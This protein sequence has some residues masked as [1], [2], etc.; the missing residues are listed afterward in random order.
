MIEYLLKTKLYKPT[1]RPFLVPRP[2]LI[3]KLDSGLNGKLTLVSAPAGFGKTTLLADWLTAQSMT[4]IAWLSLDGRDNDPARFLAY[5]VAALQ[6]IA[7]TLGDAIA[8]TLNGFMPDGKE[9]IQESALISLLNEIA[10]LSQPFILVLDDYHHITN[11]DVQNALI[12]LLDNLPP[13]MHLVIATRADPPWALSR[14]RV[15]Q[16]INELRIRDLRFTPEE[17]AVFL[18]K[19][20]ALTLSPEDIIALEART[21]GWIAGLQLAA[22]TLQKDADKS[23]FIHAFTNSNRFVF[24]YLAEEVLERQ[25]PAVQEFLLKT[26]ILAQMSDELC[27]AILEQKNV[28]GMLAQLEQSNLFLV[29][30]DNEQRW[31]RYHH[32]FADLLHN[33]LR[34]TYPDHISALHGRA[35]EWFAAQGMI[36]D[37]VDHARAADDFAQVV[38]LVKGNA[39]AMLDTGAL[40]TL[41]GWLDALPRETILAE[42]WMSLFYAWTVAYMGQTDAVERHL[43]QAEQGLAAEN[44]ENAQHLRGHIAA[45]RTFLAKLNGQMAES[46]QLANTALTDL[47]VDDFKTR[48]FVAAMLGTALQTMGDIGA[49]AQAYKTAVFTSR[50]AG[51]SH[52]AVHALCDLVGLQLLQGRL[53]QAEATCREALQL[54]ED[55]AKNSGRPLPGAAYAH[56]RLSNILLRRNDLDAALQHAKIGVHLSQQ[57]GQAD[58]LTFCFLALA[59][60]Q[61]DR[62]DAENWRQTLQQAKQVERDAAMHTAIV[63]FVAVEFGL[64]DGDVETAVNWA[65]TNQLHADNEIEAG[66]TFYYLFL[67]RLLIAQNQPDKALTLLDRLLA[68]EEK[69]GAMGLV[70]SIRILQALAWQAA[71]N[72]KQALTALKRAITIAE[73]EG[74][75]RIFMEDGAIMRPLLQ[76]LAHQGIA[77]AY[78]NQLLIALDGTKTAAPPRI[79]PLEEPL[80][81]REI[82]VLRLM[83]TE[84]RTPE[85]ADRIVVSVHT[86]RSHIKNI[87]RK[88]NVHNRYE[89]VA[90]ARQL[91]LL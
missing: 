49:A 6:Q 51:N 10:E 16:E 42:P 39:F 83:A 11:S 12:F 71:K 30:L 45:I 31:Y 86:I 44:R 52:M 36:A 55:N 38:R 61:F 19:T 70:I 80:T 90:K 77:I 79:S 68:I 81:D 64:V 27:T 88:L 3:S 32:L 33:R 87:Y 41:K 65:K 28:N 26:S 29:S 24:D 54:A 53:N 7:P 14:L 50:Q 72:N 34:Q 25:P 8:D 22:L 15:R 20:M 40:A 56:A 48:S 35:A 91:E 82:E 58:I 47:P 57:R 74:Y 43:Q 4:K 69:S 84:M 23:Q 66:Q 76:Q 89:A 1:P 46:I 9:P 78:V 17:T 5:F 60:V 85:I 73:P 67:S 62:D 59:A 63:D 2:H 13:P 18:N 37:A 75:V 21:E